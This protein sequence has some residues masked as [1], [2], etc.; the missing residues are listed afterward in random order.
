MTTCCV[1]RRWT[2]KLLHLPKRLIVRRPEQ[3]EDPQLTEQ[4]NRIVL[5]L[6]IDRAFMPILRGE[7]S[8]RDSTTPGGGWARFDADHPNMGSLP[9]HTQLVTVLKG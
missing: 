2:I 1:T 8:I 7:V 6:I 9:I 3:A 5:Q 4:Q